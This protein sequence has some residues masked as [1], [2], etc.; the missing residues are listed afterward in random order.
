MDIMV[1]E[2]KNRIADPSQL[3]Q[4]VLQITEML[5]LYQA[6]LAR[7]LRLQCRDIG[8]LSSG[9][10]VLDE[11]SQSWQ[12]TQRFLQFYQLLYTHFDGEGVAMRNWLRRENAELGG[13]PLLLM[14][15]DLKIEEVVQFFQES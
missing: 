5:G 11:D 2:I 14:V 8:Q 9:K 13:V 10:A 12:Q 1:F 3:T 15:D 7:I 4:S 6:V